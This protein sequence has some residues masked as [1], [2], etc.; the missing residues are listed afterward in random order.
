MDLPAVKRVK[1]HERVRRVFA[2]F[3]EV[4]GTKKVVNTIRP[5]HLEAYQAKRDEEGRALATVDL[6]LNEAKSLIDKAFDNDLADG[7]VLK[8]FKTVKPRLK[9][10]ANARG[11]TL[12]HPG[13]SPRACRERATRPESPARRGISYRD[14]AGRASSSSVGMDRPGEGIHQA[15]G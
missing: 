2:N 1:A 14:E 10:G 6:E 9:A 3:N 4:F 7:R 15:S 11:R 8:V 5:E 12:Y 13:G